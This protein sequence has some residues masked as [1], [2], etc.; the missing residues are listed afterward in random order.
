MISKYEIIIFWSEIDM[1]FIAEIPKLKGC[2]AHG[3]TYETTLKN[4]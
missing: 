2:L 3:S 4:V 1:A